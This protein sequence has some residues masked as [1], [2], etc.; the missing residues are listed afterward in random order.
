[1]VAEIKAA[2]EE[3]VA[4]Y[5]TVRRPKGVPVSGEM[6]AAGEIKTM[7]L[8][9][10]SVYNKDHTSPAA[11]AEP[12]HRA[13]ISR[14]FLY[15]LATYAAAF[16]IICYAA[17]GVSLAHL[18][19]SFSVANLWIFIPASV[20]SF[21]VWFVGET[22]LFATL[23]GYFHN[24]TS[25]R[26]M[27]PANAAQYFLQLINTAVAGTAL[28]M[29][30]NRRK[31]VVW[32]TAGCTLIF[33][34][35][36]DLQIMAA[37]A[38]IAAA[39][40]PS[41]LI[42]KFWHV[43][44]IILTLLLLN[45]W[46]WSRGRPESALGRWIYDRPSLASFRIARACHYLRLAGIRTTIFL[47]YGAMLYFQLHGFGINVNL[48]AVFALLPAVLLVDGLP[49]TPVGLGPVQAILVTGLAAYASRA[50]LLA[51]ALSISFMNIAFQAPLGLG[52]A[53]AF[54]REVSSIDKLG[55][56]P[57]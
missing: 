6:Y 31:G 7:R 20:G 36:L 15:R 41:A 52:S 4:N 32:L 21:T 12:P 30:M 1:V 40:D 51:M 34:A 55:R 50:R 33:Q 17:R 53:G 8:W 9:R 24:R 18:L 45:T 5:D 23:F 43:P 35:L 47:A 19:H 13:V 57:V 38:L 11:S 42:R 46:F 39:V 22:F 26:E 28:V 2:G 10:V 27:L 56:Q 25:F 54:A 16:F 3:A 44:A 37:M 48:A 29:F 14:A 49:I